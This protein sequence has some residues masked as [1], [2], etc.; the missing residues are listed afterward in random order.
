M[1]DSHFLDIAEGQIFWTLDRPTFDEGD[2][3][4]EHR[5]LPTLLFI[6]AA[7]ADYTLWDDQVAFCTSRGWYCLRYDLLGYGKSMP[8][9]SYLAKYPRPLVRHHDHA[10]LVVNTWF[11]SKN[12]LQNPAD[13]K[14]VVMAM[15]HGAYIAIDLALSHT[16]LIRGLVLCAG[17]AGGLD[18]PDSPDEEVLFA[19]LENSKRERDIQKIAETNVRIWGDGTQGEEG[20]MSDQTR[21]KL[22]TWCRDIADKE[23]ANV[24][25]GTIPYEFAHP[26]ASER[27]S[28]INFDTR[29]AIGR[30]DTSGTNAAMR[31]IALRLERVQLKEFEAAHML[32]LECPVEFNEWLGKYLGQISH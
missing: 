30:Y 12:G 23:L 14:I 21:K 2:P 20:R 32:N 8:S 19:Q 26:P 15:S 17:G 29:L 31:A 1:T 18:I 24:G 22:L 27:L 16:D 11:N 7:V 9:K 25:G 6:H 5:S 13:Q 4:R 28:A 10:A 3:Q